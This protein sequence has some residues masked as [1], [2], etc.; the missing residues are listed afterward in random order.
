MSTIGRADE[1]AAVVPDGNRH[2]A[3]GLPD[4]FEQRGSLLRVGRVERVRHREAGEQ[5]ADLVRAAAVLGRNHRNSENP[6]LLALAQLA[7]NS[8]TAG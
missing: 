2:L 5:V 1:H 7:R 6:S 8:V 3:P 4:L